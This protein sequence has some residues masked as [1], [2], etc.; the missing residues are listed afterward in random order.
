MLTTNDTECYVYLNTYFDNQSWISGTSPSLS[1]LIQHNK[2]DNIQG[3]INIFSFRVAGGSTDATG[4]RSSTVS[5]QDI[6][7]LG[8][9]QNSI[10]G[11]NGVYP[12]GPN[13]IT[14]CAV[15]LDSAGVS[16]TTPYIVS[17]RVTYSEAQA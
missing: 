17:A 7:L 9:I 1:Q 5:T 13:I 8:S 15:C 3:G 6:N 14:V 12:D 4:K 2:G 16:A 10:L 11:G